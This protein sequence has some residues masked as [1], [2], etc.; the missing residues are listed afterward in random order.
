[1][2]LEK[3]Q[4]GLVTAFGFCALFQISAVSVEKN[5]PNAEIAEI[6]QRMGPFIF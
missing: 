2:K 6:S 3:T 5:S 1:M 4:D